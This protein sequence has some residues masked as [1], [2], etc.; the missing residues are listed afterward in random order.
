MIKKFTKTRDTYFDFLL[1]IIL[2]LITTFSHL[3]FMLYL[4]MFKF[5]SMNLF[6]DNLKFK[7]L[8]LFMKYSWIETTLKWFST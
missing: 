7:I 6:L 1:S 5:K 2:S 3:N 8:I 4:N